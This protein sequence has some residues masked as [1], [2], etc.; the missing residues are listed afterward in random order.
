MI[1]QQWKRYVNECQTYYLNNFVTNWTESC[2]KGEQVLGR[3]GLKQN[4][5]NNRDL[6]FSIQVSSFIQVK[7]RAQLNKINIRAL[8]KNCDSAEKEK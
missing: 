8:F 7:L 5:R 4:S 1:M 6:D 2:S 3:F